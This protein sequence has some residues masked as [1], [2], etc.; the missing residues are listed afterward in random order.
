MADYPTRNIEDVLSFSD[1]NCD[2]CGARDGEQCSDDCQD[3]QTDLTIG[4]TVRVP[5]VKGL[6]K[7]DPLDE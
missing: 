1:G 6:Y 4:V 7:L 5:K 3:L 2:T